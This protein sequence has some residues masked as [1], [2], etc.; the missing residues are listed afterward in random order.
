MV[1]GRKDARVL[2]VGGTESLGVLATQLSVASGASQV[3][4]YDSDPARAELAARAGA[5]VHSGDE[6]ALYE[7]FDFTISATRDPEKLRASLLALAPGGHCSCIGIIF[8]DPKVPL[9][10]MYLR[11]VTLSVGLC[12]VR[13]YMPRVLDLVASGQCDPMSLTTVVN[14]DEAPHALA[15][16]AGKVVVVRPRLFA[17]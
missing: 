17:H 16:Y 3:T 13:P 2:V 12:S 14:T 7:K 5:T 9:F 11:D 4:Y 15:A 8:E 6:E 10:S 1:A